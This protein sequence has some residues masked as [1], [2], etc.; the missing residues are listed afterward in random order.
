MSSETEAPWSRSV[1]A[2]ETT[3][4]PASAPPRE[5]EPPPPSLSTDGAR[6]IHPR[7]EGEATIHSSTLVHGVTRL[8]RGARYSLIV[9]LGREPAVRRQLV[10]GEWVRTLVE[11]PGEEGAADA[12]GAVAAAPSPP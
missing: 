9:F 11:D 6:L 8:A 12:A 7:T 10:D 5:Y 4:A 2:R 1:Q 3:R